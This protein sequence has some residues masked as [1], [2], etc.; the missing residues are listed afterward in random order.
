VVTPWPVETALTLDQRMAAQSALA[1]LGFDPG[2][3]D[4]MIGAGARQAL[5]AWQKTQGLP[6][7]GYLSPAMV[8]RLKAAGKT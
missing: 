6:A 1:R 5:R 4:G 8:A 3:V 7:D 2:L